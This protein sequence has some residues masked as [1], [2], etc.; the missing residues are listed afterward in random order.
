MTFSLLEDGR[1]GTPF[2]RITAITGSNRE[3][4]AVRGNRFL[5]GRQGETIYTGELLEAN[6]TWQHGMSAGADSIGRL[7][8]SAGYGTESEKGGARL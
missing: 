4:R 3:T 2:L 8:P 5:L 6:E 1:A 7:A